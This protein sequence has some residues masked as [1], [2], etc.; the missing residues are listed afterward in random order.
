MHAILFV[1]MEIKPP[2]QR[3]FIFAGGSVFAF[4]MLFLGT[5]ALGPQGSTETQVAAVASATATASGELWFSAHPY[6]YEQIPGK[7]AFYPNLDLDN[8]R[9]RDDY[10]AELTD[11]NNWSEIKKLGKPV[12]ISI[13]S[14]ILAKGPG[15]GPSEEYLT[16]AELKEIVDFIK[17]NNFKTSLRVGGLR[18]TKDERLYPEATCAPTDSTCLG[19]GMRQAQIDFDR[20]KRWFDL[21]GTVNY[22]T[23]DH[24]L[25]FAANSILDPSLNIRLDAARASNQITM[26]HLVRELLRY[27]TSIDTLI[28][29]YYAGIGQSYPSIEVGMVVGPLGFIT[30]APGG[31]VYKPVGPANS[32]LSKTKFADLALILKNQIAAVQATQYN[33]ILE[34][35]NFSV[36][37][38]VGAHSAINDGTFA[39]WNYERILLNEASVRSNG[40]EFGLISNP[41]SYAYAANHVYDDVDVTCQGRGSCDKTP[42]TTLALA[43]K[44][45]ADHQL[46]FLKEYLSAGGN[47]QHVEIANW[48]RYPSA[49]GPVDTL[50]SWFATARD[51]AFIYVRNAVAPEGK[52]QS[53]TPG[54]LA[55]TSPYRRAVSLR[56]W[57]DGVATTYQ[58]Q[59]VRYELPS[60]TQN[61]Y[62]SVNLTSNTTNKNFSLYTEVQLVAPTSANPGW[63]ALH[64]GK[65]AAGEAVWANGYSLLMRPNGSLSLITPNAG[66]ITNLTTVENAFSPDEQF[67]LEMRVQRNKV[68]VYIN[69]KE[70]LAHIIAGTTSISGYISLDSF[71]Q[72]AEFTNPIVSYF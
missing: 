63:A 18:L 40:F 17:R 69:Y 14:L 57:H 41:G 38:D 24:P 34:P 8:D 59:K 15:V 7:L 20:L 61:A 51:A 26:A 4:V 44:L 29:N 12:V 27:Y 66:A 64:L 6:A 48:G 23:T 35:K 56:L 42:A 43:N 67:V 28:R 52:V 5:M 11:D 70:V 3:A 16:D 46:R 71:K 25:Q 55:A 53:T 37:F 62:R 22:I 50:Y 30:N 58:Y 39:N 47:P 49:T 19:E 10:V 54:N 45:G 21:G 33:S 13:H 72:D 65:K 32:L 1:R 9:V 36:I 31:K 2:G 60:L 68:T